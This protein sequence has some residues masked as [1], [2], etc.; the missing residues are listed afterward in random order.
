[1]TAVLRAPCGRPA[2]AGR[3]LG[4]QQGP[5][6][7]NRSRGGRPAGRCGLPIRS[8]LAHSGCPPEPVRLAPHSSAGWA[9][10]AA[11]S[12]RGPRMPAPREGP[13]RGRP[14]SGAWLGREARPPGSLRRGFLWAWLPFNGRSA[15]IGFSL[16]S[17]PV[18]CR[19][20][21]GLAGKRGARRAGCGPPLALFAPA[22]PPGAL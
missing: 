8:A 12:A 1:M 3:A 7:Q 13:A 4:L 20:R 18:P 6:P 5:R 21:W 2:A 9:S 11:H 22:G 16:A 14:L 19:P 10:G 15:L 17:P